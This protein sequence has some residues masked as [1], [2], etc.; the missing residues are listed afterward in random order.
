M[1]TAAG[2]IENIMA[3]EEGFFEQPTTGANMP[4][5]TALVTN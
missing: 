1:V 5:G 2:M 4:L 3:S